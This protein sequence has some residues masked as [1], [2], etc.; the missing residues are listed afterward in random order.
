MLRDSNSASLENIPSL[1][2]LQWAGI[3]VPLLRWQ[4]QSWIK[5]RDMPDLMQAQ[6]PFTI[7]SR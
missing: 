6:R 5:W 7:G 2:S 4:H 1:G 3:S